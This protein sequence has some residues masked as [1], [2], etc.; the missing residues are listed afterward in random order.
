MPTFTEDRCPKCG[1]EP[2]GIAHI[3]RGELPHRWVNYCW[4]DKPPVVWKG[5]ERFRNARIDQRLSMGK[6]APKLDLKP[7]DLSAYEYG[8]AVPPVGLIVRWASELGISATP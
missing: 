5:G 1:G 4:C 8:R 2:D 6:L 3:N 7:A